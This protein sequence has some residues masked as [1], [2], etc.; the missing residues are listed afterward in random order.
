MKFFENQCLTL[1]H[2]L[3]CEG[4][5][6]DK[7]QMFIS[8]YCRDIQYKYVQIERFSSININ[9]HKCTHWF[10]QI[11][12]LLGFRCQNFLRILPRMQFSTSSYTVLNQL[13]KLVIYYSCSIATCRNRIRSFCEDMGG[14]YW[15]ILELFQFCYFYLMN[16]MLCAMSGKNQRLDPD[17]P[18]EGE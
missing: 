2:Q 18:V 12:Y 17:E 9:C 3:D 15:M 14:K 1:R 5:R 11:Y 4:F 6:Q 7:S 10:L 8:R 13:V 16:T